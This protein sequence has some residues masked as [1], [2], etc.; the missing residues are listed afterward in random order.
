MAYSYQDGGSS[1]IK[2]FYDENPRIITSIAVVVLIGLVVFL[3]FGLPQINGFAPIPDFYSMASPPQRENF[4]AYN[5]IDH[6]EGVIVAANTG[7]AGGAPMPRGFA[8]TLTKCAL[9]SCGCANKT[10]CSCGTFNTSNAERLV[11][12]AKNSVTAAN[13]LRLNAN[14]S[15]TASLKV[16][17]KVNEVVS[18]AENVMESNNK[19]NAALKKGDTA[20]ANKLLND[21]KAKL[22]NANNN[23]NDLNVLVKGDTIPFNS[24]ANIDPP[25]MTLNNNA[26]YA[27]KKGSGG[28]LVV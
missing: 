11:A 28:V 3:L 9:S 1:S 25:V 16:N 24:R 22:S 23:V 21:M 15:S 19:L 6:P 8:K 17:R 14:V 5:A 2:S 20:E 26:V 27:Y 7:K 10:A 12:S 4:K 18:S 13:R